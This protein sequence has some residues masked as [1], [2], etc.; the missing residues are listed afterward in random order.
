MD[1]VPLKYRFRKSD[2]KRQNFGENTHAIPRS[3]RD[4]RRVVAIEVM[5]LS[6]DNVCEKLGFLKEMSKK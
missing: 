2:S 3:D 1:K 6:G 4:W 5:Q